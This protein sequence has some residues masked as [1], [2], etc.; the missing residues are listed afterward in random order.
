MLLPGAVAVVVAGDLS[1]RRE[2][3]QLEGEGGGQ[4]GGG[5]LVSLRTWGAE[6]E[7]TEMMD[8]QTRGG[9]RVM[10]NS[11]K[12]ENNVLSVNLKPPPSYCAWLRSLV[13]LF[14]SSRVSGNTMLKPALTSADGWSS[15]GG[16]EG[17]GGTFQSQW[18]KDMA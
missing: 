15:V 9:Q 13:T 11:V 17:G 1:V 8:T 10:D 2:L 16:A 4:L 3:V 5:G 7:M 6:S 18:S 14:L 12:L